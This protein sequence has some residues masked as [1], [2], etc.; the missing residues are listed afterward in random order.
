MRSYV[1]EGDVPALWKNLMDVIA[2]G[3]SVFSKLQL[4]M[5]LAPGVLLTVGLPT[6]IAACR[7]MR[8]P[9]STFGCEQSVE[10]AVAGGIVGLA[11]LPGAPD[12]AE[13]GAAEDAEGVRVVVS[14]GAG[15]LVDVGGPGVVVA[16]AVGE[17][18]DGAA[19]VFVAG[20]AEAGDFLLAG[21]DG[22]GGLSGDRFE[23]GACWVAISGVAD[24]GEQ[25]GGGD[26]ALGVAEEREEDGAVVVGADGACDRQRGSG[27]S[28]PATDPAAFRG[29]LFRARAVGRFSGIEL[30]FA[31]MSQGQ[32][33][34][35]RGFA[36]LGRERNGS[37]LEEPDEDED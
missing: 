15:A 10:A 8:R 27:S 35:D 9:V 6:R 36:E 2:D 32:A 1:D 7:R 19:Q 29:R 25:L 20:P 11:V 34:S 14:A 37:F 18:A 21:L 4:I 24:L 16:A 22:D 5:E 26:D 30:G 13:P 12:D 17:D 23:R 28:V 31:F 33:T 3:V